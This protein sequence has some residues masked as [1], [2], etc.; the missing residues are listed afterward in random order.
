MIKKVRIQRTKKPRL[1]RST[2]RNMAIGRLY[3]AVL[4]LFAHKQERKEKNT[5][6]SARITKMAADT[7]LKESR[8]SA[9]IEETRYKELRNIKLAQQLGMKTGE[10]VPDFI[11]RLYETNPNAAE[12]HWRGI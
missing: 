7:R 4:Q 12:D 10:S 2:K 3:L 8:D 11:E 5:L 1:Y 6:A 9:L